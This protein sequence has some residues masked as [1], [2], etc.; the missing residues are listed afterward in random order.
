MRF[1]SS[2][3][4]AAFLGGS[5]HAQDA[6]MFLRIYGRLQADRI[7]TPAFP[8]HLVLIDCEA[9]SPQ[10]TV[11]V[12][13]QSGVRVTEVAPD[14][15]LD[16]LHCAWR[17]VVPVGQKELESNLIQSIDTDAIRQWRTTLDAP[18][19]GLFISKG[20]NFS[21]YILPIGPEPKGFSLAVEKLE[22]AVDQAKPLAKP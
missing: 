16:F 15:S 5:A 6:T 17:R 3:L 2:T 8:G 7:V 1:L 22:A 4:L 19:G 21:C 10:W 13:D 14:G 18:M 9:F 20:S 12:M 11:Y